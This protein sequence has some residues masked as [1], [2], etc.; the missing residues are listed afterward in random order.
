MIQK[1]IQRAQ[2]GFTLIEL[3]IVVAIIGILAAIALPQYQDY[4]SRSRYASVLSGLESVKRGWE[5]CMGSN[6]GDYTNCAVLEA[7]GGAGKLELRKVDG[8]RVTEF[9]KLKHTDGTAISISATDG[10]IA[11]KGDSSSGSCAMEVIPNNVSGT[12]WQW[13]PRIAAS[14]TSTKCNKSSTGFSKATGS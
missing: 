3:M 14:E 13:E 2:R 1:Q 11:F 5:L 12:T 7:D 10:R 6:A 9:P 8:S 4:T